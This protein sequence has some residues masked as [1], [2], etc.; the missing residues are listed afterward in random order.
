VSNWYLAT[1]GTG[2]A[3]R[4]PLPQDTAIFDLNSGAHVCTMDT[5]RFGNWTCTGATTTFTQTTASGYCYGNLIGPSTLTS[6][7]LV[8]YLCGRG[9]QTVSGFS[10]INPGYRLWINAPGGSYTQQNNMLCALF[11]FQAGTY[12][13]NGYNIN[14]TVFEALYIQTTAPVVV[15][16]GS[17]TWTVSNGNASGLAWTFGTTTGLTVN[18]GT[19][20]LN[21]QPTIAGALTFAGGGYTCLSDSYH[22]RFKFFFFVWLP[23]R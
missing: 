17:G 15:N 20:T 9:S 7:N 10:S 12:N 19:S 3:G 18:C 8:M 16:M 23:G 4:V 22:Y 1:D 21:W 11:V 6:P 14:A 13:A 2:G 5:E